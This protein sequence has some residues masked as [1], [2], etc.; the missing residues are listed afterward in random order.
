MTAELCNFVTYYLNLRV[1]HLWLVLYANECKKK[2][3]RH[4]S[5][6]RKLGRNFTATI[7]MVNLRF[8]N[9]INA[10]TLRNSNTTA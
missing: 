4:K 10:L 5:I 1:I 2:L 6:F 7:A 9:Y 8:K 3:S